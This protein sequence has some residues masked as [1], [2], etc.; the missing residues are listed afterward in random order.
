MAIPEIPE[1]HREPAAAGGGENV[2]FRPETRRRDAIYF[3]DRF[4]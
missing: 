4:P 1:N 2:T 3:Y